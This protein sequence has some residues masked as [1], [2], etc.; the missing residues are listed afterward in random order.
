MNPNT[1]NFFT[2]LLKRLNVDCVCDIGSLDGTQA[3]R[4][5]N[6]LPG[7]RIFAFEANPHNFASMSAHPVIRDSRITLVPHAVAAHDGELDFHVVDVDYAD[8]NANRGLSSLYQC[9][10]PVRETV[11]VKAVRIDDFLDCQDTAFGRIALWIDVEGAAFDVLQGME[12]IRDRVAMIHVEVEPRGVWREQKTASD[13][14][15][16][17][18]RW[19]YRQIASEWWLDRKQG[20]VL[21][22][23]T[24]PPGP[25]R[26][27]IAVCTARAWLATGIDFCIQPLRVLLKG[28]RH[29]LLYRAL[30]SFYIRKII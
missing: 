11:K 13:I 2:S 10:D 17:C 12:R 29:S 28:T 4:F 23:K 18:A 30:K 9:T 16:L 20:N 24:S 21:F 26:L 8:E 3:V 5:R 22:V 15:T 6:A 14:E 7:T 25:T 19:G 1:G 27:D